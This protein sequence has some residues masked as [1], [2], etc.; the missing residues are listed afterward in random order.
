MYDPVE[1]YLRPVVED[2]IRNIISNA[3]RNIG[4]IAGQSAN[5][6][7]GKRTRSG[8]AK[9]KKPS[10]TG[11]G[12]KS[13][14]LSGGK[15]KPLKKTKKYKR[16]QRKRSYVGAKGVY[17]RLESGN[18]ITPK[19]CGYVGHH[20]MPRNT[21]NTHVWRALLKAL[22][23]KKGYTIKNFSDLSSDGV[24][25]GT[26]I[27]FTYRFNFDD[28]TALS[29]FEYNT[30]GADTWEQIAFT[31]GGQTFNRVDEFHLVTLYLLDVND[32]K[33]TFNLIGAKITVD[34]KSTLKI[35]NRSKNSEGADEAD[36]VDCV[37]LYGKFYEVQSGG[38]RYIIDQIGTYRKMV[39]N[40]ISG[41]IDVTVDTNDVTVDPNA[42]FAEPPF[43]S[44]F[45]G[46][47]KSG[48][49]HLDPSMIKTSTLTEKF[50][51]SLDQFLNKMFGAGNNTR[52]RGELGKTRVFAIEKMLEVNTGVLQTIYPFTIAY[53]HD[54]KLGFVI[55]EGWS[56][57]STMVI[58]DT[59]GV[60]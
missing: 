52:V 59:L 44:F 39:A 46:V 58:D 47:K 16:V 3:S 60:S 14:G 34:A 8:T 37:P 41:N 56:T 7:L 36:D 54:L 49:V 29:S 2:H 15:F 20:T 25:A 31:F 42:V 30:S 35:Q 55:K 11:R 4:N 32:S 33:T 40:A 53:E 22:M 45:I 9:Q 10:R 51:M 18:E 12:S 23:L 57:K 50:S 17:Y 48:K 19:R 24:A 28:G 5:V 21:V 43:P 1:K 26:K 27:G 13:T 38:L 6:V